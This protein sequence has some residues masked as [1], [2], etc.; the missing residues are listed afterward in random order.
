MSDAVKQ[1]SIFMEHGN[2]LMTAVINAAAN[3]NVSIVELLNL[4]KDMK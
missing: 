1:V 3:C 2:E 4:V